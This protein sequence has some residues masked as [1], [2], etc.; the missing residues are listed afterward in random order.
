M[1][2]TILIIDDDT[3][4]NRLLIDFLKDFGFKAV[5]ATRPG[6][7]LKPTWLSSTSCSRE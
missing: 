5:S 6:E 7:G 2:A 3:K 4:L 1:N